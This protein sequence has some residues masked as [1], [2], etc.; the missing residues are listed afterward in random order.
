MVAI[1]GFEADITDAITAV[2]AIVAIG[3]YFWYYRS[4]PDDRY[5]ILFYLVSRLSSQ[6]CFQRK[7]AAAHCGFS[8]C[9]L[10]SLS[11]F[12]KETFKSAC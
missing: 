1:L 11:N 6:I 5:V 9:G 12:K 10:M 7:Y 8:F 2:V 3:F 4:K